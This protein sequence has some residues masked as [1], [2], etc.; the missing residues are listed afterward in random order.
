MF[1]FVDNEF[2]LWFSIPFL[3]LMYRLIAWV[4]D[5]VQRGLPLV[6][7]R[8]ISVCNEANI[9]GIP[10]K[11][12]PAGCLEYSSAPLYYWMSSR[13][14]S[15][16]VNVKLT[17]WS[18]FLCVYPLIDDKFRYNIVR[19]YCGTTRLGFVVPV[20]LTMLWGNLSSTR[21]QPHKNWISCCNFS[22]SI[23]T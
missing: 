19:V 15:S 16:A 20:T 2:T 14:R 22:V 3:V 11:W 5:A 7:Y 10:W 18:Q 23:L 4:A 1:L 12:S 17:N 6:I 13:A 21:G 8:E 9:L